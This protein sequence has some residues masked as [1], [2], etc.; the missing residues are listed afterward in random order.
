MSQYEFDDYQNSAIARLASAM[1]F[2]AIFEL[3]GGV[4]YGV[5][6][7][8]GVVTGSVIT[9]LVYGAIAVVTIVIALA[10]NTASTSMRAVVGTRGADIAHMM[11]ALEQLRRYFNIQRIMLIVLLSLIALA[12]VAG[13]LLILRN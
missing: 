9:A 8:L 12:L 11:S 4:I 2:V 10:L 1:K 6:A 7:A 13:F 3:V 5:F